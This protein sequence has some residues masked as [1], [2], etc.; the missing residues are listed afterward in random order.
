[1]IYFR[2][3]TI[4][5]CGVTSKY[6]KAIAYIRQG[7]IFRL[8]GKDVKRNFCPLPGPPI[9]VTPDLPYAFNYPIS[10]EWAPPTGD[11]RDLMYTVVWKATGTR[12]R[13]GFPPT[14]LT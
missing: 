14:A 3:R 6:S 12:Y 9:I 2:M 5:A 8:Y 13:K 10:V 11:Y 1:M 7:E 4:N